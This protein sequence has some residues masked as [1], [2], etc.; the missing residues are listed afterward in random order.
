MS[1][2]HISSISLHVI[3]GMCGFKGCNPYLE[4]C[5]PSSKVLQIKEIKSAEFSMID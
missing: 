3:R 2:G 4:K 1:R 5:F